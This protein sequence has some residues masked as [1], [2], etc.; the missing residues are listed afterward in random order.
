MGQTRPPS[1]T[2]C[3]FMGI[4]ER[5]N[6]VEE[7]ARSK[8]KKSAQVNQQINQT[9]NGYTADKPSSHEVERT[10]KKN[11]NVY[12]T[13]DKALK[14]TGGL[15]VRLSTFRKISKGNRGLS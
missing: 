1:E 8:V 4:I 12:P 7:P 6:K 11:L 2:G 14:T 13:G 3:E 9:T 10:R 15:R 5:R